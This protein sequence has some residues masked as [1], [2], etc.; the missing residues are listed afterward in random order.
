MWCKY[1]HHGWFQANQVLIPSLQNSWKFT[2]QFLWISIYPGILGFSIYISFRECPFKKI[3]F[4]GLIVFQGRKKKKKITDCFIL[5]NMKSPVLCVDNIKQKKTPFPF[6]RFLVDNMHFP[7]DSDGK[8]SAYN[9]GRP[10]FNPCLGKISWRRKWQPT[11]VLLPGKSCGC[12][13]LVGYS[14]WGSKSWT[15]WE[16]SLS[17]L[18]VDKIFTVS[19]HFVMSFGK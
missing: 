13:S 17:F 1:S 12:R 11:P 19:G 16:T 7:C 5:P 3:F 9:A 14:P 18:L 15:D 4:H 2:H 10:R 6:S 8:A